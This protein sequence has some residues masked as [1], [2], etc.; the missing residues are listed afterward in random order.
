[1]TPLDKVTTLLS[2]R[3]I[4]YPVIAQK[5]GLSYQTV[6]R[7]AREPDSLMKT[8][9]RNLL[10]L[11][12]VYN[13]VYEGENKL[14]KT[15]KQEYINADNY[16]KDRTISHSS[17]LRRAHLSNSV[18]ARYRRGDI[19]IIDIRVEVLLVLSNSWVR[20]V[21]DPGSVPQ[22]TN[23]TKT[24]TPNEIAVIQEVIDDMSVSTSDLALDSNVDVAVISKLRNRQRPIAQLRQKTAD[25]LIAYYYDGND[26][27]IIPRE[28]L[29][30]GSKSA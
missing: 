26:D 29:E 30:R 27:P 22:Y 25:K 15:D 3:K 12:A 1:M 28:N 4:E 8:T 18:Y 17:D 11:V 7:F 6:C 5:T 24:I 10:K 13:E 23:G 19:D 16:L 9:W 2:E 14:F 21:E 20:Y